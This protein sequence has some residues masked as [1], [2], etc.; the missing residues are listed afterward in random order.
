MGRRP[1]SSASMSEGFTAW[2][3]PEQMNRMWSVFTFP[4]FVDTTLRCR[5]VP[6]VSS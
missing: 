6:R 4:N 3:A 1:C 5:R 2:K